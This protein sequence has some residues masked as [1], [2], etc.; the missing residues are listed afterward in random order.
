[1]SEDVAGT[2]S[3][4]P[5]RESDATTPIAF[6]AALAGDGLA[7]V[8]LV[9][10]DRYALSTG[11]RVTP[12]PADAEDLRF[13]VD[14]AVTVTT[15][16]VAI[17][18]VPAVLVR[19]GEGAMLATT[20]PPFERSFPAGEYHLEVCAPIKL[21]LRV[22]GPMTVTATVDGKRVAFDDERPVVV[23][24]RSKHEHPAATVTTT[25]DPRDVMAAVSTFGSAL[26]TT[27]PE[28]SF[29]T[30]RGHPPT[31][32]RGDTL[33]VP[34]GLA[35]PDT[36]VEVV[37]PPDYRHVYPVAPLAYYLG[38]EVVPGDRPQ[39][40]TD[41]GLTHDLAPDDG[42]ERE[43][44]RVLT[45][46]FLL[47]CVTRTE[48]L[49]DVDLHERAAIESRVDL[50]AAALY[51]RPLAERLAAYLSVPH[52]RVADQVPTW[53]LTTDVAAAPDTIPALPFVVDDLAV[54]RT[55]AGLGATTADDSGSAA[56]QAAVESFMRSSA[57]DA[58]ARP[59]VDLPSTDAMEHAWV[60]D[61]VPRGA[62][63]AT[64]AAY[65]N[66]LERSP[67]EGDIA[68]TV[69][70]N[71]E[72]MLA[73]RD[74]VDEAYRSE[75][76]AVDVTVR[77]RLTTAELRAAL[78]DDVEF[79]HYIGHIDDDGFECADG[80]LDA[81][82]V[83]ET[84]VD[85]F[86]LNAC[87]SY[88]QGLALVEAGAVGGVV[89]LADVVN[90]SAVRVG[91]TVA[92]LLDNGYPL[93]AALD[94]AKKA[95]YAGGDYTVV[96]DGSLTVA[97]RASM[98]P[99]LHV[100]EPSEEGA[101]LSIYS[102]ANFTGGIGTIFTPHLDGV[103]QYYI[104]SGHLDDFELEEARLSEYLSLDDVPVEAA[105]ELWWPDELSLDE[106]Q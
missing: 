45:R 2:A 61:G 67:V 64:A 68:V 21:Y 9:E 33:S 48:G 51:D 91:S 96:G 15:D 23:G 93:G 82:T 69:V 81:A 32:E 83:A 7:I 57:G 24:A 3:P 62:S 31:V 60:G 36:G 95:S 39:L 18:D 74:V 78:A 12:R 75:D 42:F 16:A 43:V 79:L 99:R 77:E 89:T 72:A 80:T 106:L 104:S 28:R 37:V 85:A 58:G 34:E 73:E 71:D 22:E 88:D 87:T 94:V 41:A 8:D 98:E 102:Y 92:R 59:A 90:E 1:M 27:S 46:T 63:K 76:A 6:Q 50:D 44:E 10:R 105:G 97:T 52:E 103:D 100:V 38:A 55:D 66:R 47:D 40:R 54:V 65:R 19:D 29:P 49:Y 70:C 14:A 84:G 13:P 20:D 17:D 4:S 101:E 5:A 11:G 26:K 35:P 56:E 25:D 30:L 53:H 86:V